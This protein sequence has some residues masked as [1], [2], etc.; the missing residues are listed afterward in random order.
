MNLQQWRLERTAGRSALAEFEQRHRVW[1][2]RLRRRAVLAAGAVFVLILPFSLL[3][4]SWWQ[5][6]VGAALGAALAF[7]LCVM[8]EPPEHVDRWRRGSGGERRTARALRPLAPSEWAVRHDLSGSRGNRDHVIVGR[9]GIFLL[10][11]KAFGGVVRI[12]N[13]VV[14]V[15]WHEDGEDGYDL[16][17]L[18]RRMR[19][20]AASLAAELA[21][22]SGVRAWVQPVVV[23]WADFAQGLVESDGVVYVHGDR[24]AEWLLGS[25]ERIAAA[26]ATK[27]KSALA[28]AVVAA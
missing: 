10:D 19:G 12:E 27:L 4:R 7:Y 23:V 25:P 8:D 5:F 13:G 2:E 15:R 9:A 14:A 21:S 1:R 16:P 26:T 6:D 20:A 22:A 28:D 18:G 3:W 24:V 17:N 11:S